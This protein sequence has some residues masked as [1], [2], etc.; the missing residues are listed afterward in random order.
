MDI[1]LHYVI[2]AVKREECIA[3]FPTVPKD[4]LKP[5][6]LKKRIEE[7][8]KLRNKMMHF[9]VLMD[10]GFENFREENGRYFLKNCTDKEINGKEIE[11]KYY[12][13]KQVE[14]FDGF[15]KS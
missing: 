6:N 3:K 10:G 4:I 12:K 8:S 7:I 1:L 14:F 2:S 5:K 11:V 9:R 13:N 15:L